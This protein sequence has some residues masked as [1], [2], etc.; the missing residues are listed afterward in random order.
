MIIM[1]LILL[2]ACYPLYQLLQPLRSTGKPLQQSRLTSDIQHA[3][4][5]ETL[6]V[7]EPVTYELSAPNEARRHG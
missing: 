7:K 1:T 4:H 2:A 6:T 5:L 3:A